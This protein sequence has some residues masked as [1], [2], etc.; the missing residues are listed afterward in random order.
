MTGKAVT[1][2][3]DIPNSTWWWS[4]EYEEYCSSYSQLLQLSA[5]NGDRVE[6]K[7]LVDS[8]LVVLV[9]KYSM[10]PTGLYSIRCGRR[11]ENNL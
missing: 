9:T 11:M 2:L 10:P 5:D 1:I 8:D 7:M 6:K 4:S 3:C